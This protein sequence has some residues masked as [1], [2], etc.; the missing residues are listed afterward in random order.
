MVGPSPIFFG[1]SHER[2]LPSE[3]NDGHLHREHRG[4]LA[5]RLQLLVRFELTLRVGIRFEHLERDRRFALEPIEELL[6]RTP[7]RGYGGGRLWC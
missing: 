4:E 7:D 6:L 2:R 1:P 5:R 3:V